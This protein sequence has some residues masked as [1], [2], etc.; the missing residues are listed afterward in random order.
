MV[1]NIYFLECI[2]LVSQGANDTGA[3]A[4]QI[5]GAAGDLSQQ[6]IRLGNEVERYLA[7]VRKAV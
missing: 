6:S 2:A 7:E 4:G 3:A 1:L 5:L